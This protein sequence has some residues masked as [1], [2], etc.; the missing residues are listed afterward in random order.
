MSSRNGLRY[1]KIFLVMLFFVQTTRSEINVATMG[2]ASQSSDQLT[3]NWKA[4]KAIDKCTNQDINNDCCTHTKA[5][6]YK[7]AWWRVDLKQ[8]MT[9][10]R[11][12]IY[13]RA[14]SEYRF[15]WILTLRVKLYQSPTQGIL[16]YK[17]NS[18]LSSDV[19][20]NPTH[21]CPSVARYVTVYNK[22]E[23]PPLRAW[24][25]NYSVLELC[26][27]Q[28]FGCQKGRYGSGNCDNL[29]PPNLLRRKL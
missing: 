4:G 19:S 16:C 7:Q 1:W 2:F 17:D 24:Y 5:G 8:A 9:I 26:E 15:W 27:V 6:H 20:L 18:S 29:C 21:E 11:I 22:R 13:Y 14:N 3:D 28:V 25:G 23:T 12:T 10:Q